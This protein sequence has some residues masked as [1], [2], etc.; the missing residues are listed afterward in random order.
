[1]LAHDTMAALTFRARRFAERPAVVCGSRQLSYVELDDR[2]GRLAQILAEAGLRAGEVASVYGPVGWEWVVAYHAVLRAGA[3]VNP[4]NALLTADEVGFMLADCNSIF[5]L[6]DSSRRETLTTAGLVSNITVIPFEDLEALTEQGPALPLPDDVSTEAISTVC[7]TSGTTGRP[8]GAMLSHQSVLMNAALTA[9]MHGRGSQDITVS[10]LPLAHVYGTA[11]MNSTLLS[12]GQLVLLPAFDPRSTIEAIVEHRATRFEGVPTMYYRLL[13]ELS[14]VDARPQ[15]LTMCTVGG[16]T[17]PFDKMRL[18]E[19]AFGC[20]LIELWGMSEIGGLGTTF[21]WT[22]PRTLG[23]IGIPLPFMQVRVVEAA[24]GKLLGDGEVGELQIRGPLVMNGYLGNAAATAEVL[25]EDGW[26]STGDVV[27]IEADGNIYVID[28]AKDLILTSGNNV[29]PAEIER[30]I[31]D[32]PGV[33]M[34]GVGRDPHPD[35]GEV[36]HAYLVLVAGAEISEGEVIAHCRAHL[37]PYKI[38]RSVSFVA[39]IPKTSSGKI[40]RRALAGLRP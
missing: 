15:S 39:D 12:G 38:P 20:P 33:V 21:P 18:V 25:S 9:L 17:M 11:V 14:K 27:R 5:L 26:L 30:V 2:V 35:K 16:Q 37:A 23:S 10:A 1:M 28:R 40:M 29:Y 34:V 19:E 22:G 24:T 32:L 3:M 7:Y 8:K 4:V 36:P 31:G 6:A 13:T